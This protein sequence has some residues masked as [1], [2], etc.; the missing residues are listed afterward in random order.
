MF[1]LRLPSTRF[2]S[3][4][5]DCEQTFRVVQGCE[6]ARHMKTPL[7]SHKWD[8]ITLTC[9]LVPADFRATDDGIIIGSLIMF[10]DWSVKHQQVF[11]C[12]W[13]ISIDLP[14]WIFL[15][16]ASEWSARKWAPLKV[17]V[18]WTLCRPSNFTRVV[19]NI[20]CFG[21]PA[22]AAVTLMDSMWSPLRPLSAIKT[23][24]HFL[25]SRARPPTEPSQQ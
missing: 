11:P 22:R 15:K 10:A 2:L 24:T 6:R 25:I 7:K 16:D 8:E 1:V 17:Q 9:V 4:A 20:P 18:R 3:Q 12:Y 14:P 13:A 21:A 23:G 5:C 19:F